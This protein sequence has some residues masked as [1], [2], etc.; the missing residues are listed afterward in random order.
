MG[1]NCYSEQKCQKGEYAWV[2]M[3]WPIIIKLAGLTL[4]K[5]VW[6]PKSLKKNNPTYITNIAK[7][8][9]REDLLYRV[10]RGQC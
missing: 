4:S 2:P 3:T 8:A 1:Q 6:I 5:T 10:L 7:Q 9:V